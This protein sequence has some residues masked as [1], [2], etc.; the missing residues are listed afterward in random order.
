MKYFAEMKFHQ[1][2]M[3]KRIDKTEVYFAKILLKQSSSFAK[4]LDEISP[5]QNFCK[6]KWIFSLILPKFW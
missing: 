4:I 5:K 2:E 1:N 3:A 6:I